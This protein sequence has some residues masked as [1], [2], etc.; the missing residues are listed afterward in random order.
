M[1]VEVNGSEIVIRRLFGRKVI[2]AGEIGSM[3]LKSTEN[4]I[5][6]KSGKKIRLKL[7][8]FVNYFVADELSA[9][10][11]NYHISFEK[12]IEYSETGVYFDD[13]SDV[14]LRAEADQRTY[15]TAID[16][17]VK[18]KLSDACSIQTEIVREA[19]NVC[20]LFNIVKDGMKAFP[21]SDGAPGIYK[22]K[23]GLREVYAMDL[24]DEARIVKYDSVT[25]SCRWLTL[26]DVS[27]MISSMKNTIDEMCVNGIVYAADEGTPCL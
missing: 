13:I 12:E 26:D 16:P 7:G 5:R 1:N 2:E 3:R 25:E 21:I 24:L 10:A 6:L 17:Y 18:E 4:F 9:L 22:E 8:R 27:N 20:L 14:M 11:L 23:I 15:E 19:D